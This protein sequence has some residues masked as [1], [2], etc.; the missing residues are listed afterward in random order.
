MAYRVCIL[1]LQ[2]SIVYICSWLLSFG[3]RNLIVV[4]INS[5][6]ATFA[7]LHVC[8][9]AM[10]ADLYS[11]THAYCLFVL[12][13][14]AITIVFGSHC[15]HAL[16]VWLFVFYIR[17]TGKKIQRVENC[18]SK[19]VPQVHCVPKKCGTWGFVCG[20]QRVK[21]VCWTCCKLWQFS[22]ILTL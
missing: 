9:F 20:K 7:D 3:S 22:V 11:Y 5:L 19:M 14:E 6:F 10:F 18:T 21:C 13:N 8:K 1:L 15:A 2:Y 4:V 16:S 17:F 12:L